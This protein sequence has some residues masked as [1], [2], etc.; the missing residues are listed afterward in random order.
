[1]AKPKQ[2]SKELIPNSKNQNSRK[3]IG[4]PKF[5]AWRMVKLAYYASS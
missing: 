1:M 5:K 4:K 3:L 2:S